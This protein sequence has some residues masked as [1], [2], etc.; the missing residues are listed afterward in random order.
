MKS[1][2]S[3]IKHSYCVVLHQII[4]NK[5]QPGML[6]VCEYG[7]VFC[8]CFVLRFWKSNN[9]WQQQRI[10]LLS[11]GICTGGIL[12]FCIKKNCC[13][14]LLSTWLSCFFAINVLVTINR[15]DNDHHHGHHHHC[16]ICL[17][18][19]FHFDYRV[20][21]MCLLCFALCGWI[22]FY[23]KSKVK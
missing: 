5:N 20:W 16:F 23:F 2:Q 4:I 7:E 3:N 10:K 12:F 21:F 9:I 15:N 11:K 22:F 17:N 6:F 18:D 14:K 1:H 19:V 13:Y 8:C